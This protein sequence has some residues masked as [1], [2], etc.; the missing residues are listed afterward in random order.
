MQNINE[1]IGVEVGFWGR[2]MTPL[3]FVW[4]GRRHEVK[5]VTMNFERTDGGKKYMCFAVDTGGMV[6]EL[7]L[8]REDL[9]WKLQATETI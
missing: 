3:R 9:I 4:N 2:R 8:D 7:V 5:R 6:A 1:L